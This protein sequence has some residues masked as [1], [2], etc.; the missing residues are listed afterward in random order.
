MGIHK[1]PRQRGWRS[2]GI[3]IYGATDPSHG[4]SK[5]QRR[6]DDISEVSNLQM[7]YPGKQKNRQC[8]SK[9]SPENGQSVK[10]LEI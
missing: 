3:A 9:D 10:T 5:G 1:G 2:I 8:R 4:L 6:G 7:F